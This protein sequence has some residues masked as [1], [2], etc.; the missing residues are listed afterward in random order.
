MLDRRTHALTPQRSAEFNKKAILNLIRNNSPISRTDIWDRPE[1]SRASVTLIIKQLIADDF[2]FELGHGESSGGRRP[3][4]LEFNKNTRMILAFNWHLRKLV[5][6]NLSS[7]VLAQREVDFARNAKPDAFVRTIKSEVKTLLDSMK[8]DSERM[9]GFG[10]AMPGLI[11]GENNEKVMLS[12]EQGWHDVKLKEMLEKET[13][14]EVLLEEDAFV[15]AFGEYLGGTGTE[16][17]SFVLFDIEEVGIG[18]ALIT[19]GKLQKGANK[20]LGEVGHIR[21]AE[22]GPLCSCGRRG[23]LQAII[24]QAVAENGGDWTGKPAK[25]VGWGIALVINTLDPMMVVVAGPVADGGGDEFFS[26]VKRSALENI[27]DA[28]GREIEIRKAA[29]GKTGWI[30]GITGLLLNRFFATY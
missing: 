4:L 13:G 16:A 3:V 11:G 25:Y 9:L 17:K 19:D 12:T 28:D 7:E 21:I 24:L 22:D 27:L 29:L 23:C 18:I 2:V 1:L 10:V 15:D 26:E 30:R 20:M 5:V 14:L 6:A 8:L